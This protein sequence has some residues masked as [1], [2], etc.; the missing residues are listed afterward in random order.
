MPT[1]DLLSRLPGNLREYGFRDTAIRLATELVVDLFPAD[2]H[3]RSKPS[4]EELYR[5][6][7]SLHYSAAELVSKYVLGEKSCDELDQLLA[8]YGEA[9]VELRNRYAEGLSRYP[10]D[11][12]L[13]EG[14]SFLLY[15]LV[16]AA[17]PRTV[18]ETGVANGHSSFLV[19]QAMLANGCGRLHS[20]DIASDVGGL[21][22]PREKERWQL[23]LLDPS[24]LK[25]SFRA[26]LDVL[27]EMDLFLHD[28]DH[29][30]QW[31]S[32][33]LHAVS[34]RLAKKAII[35]ADDVD[36]SHAFLDFCVEH[37]TRPILL[38]DRRKVF[39]LVIPEG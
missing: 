39:G 26:L 19:L 16:R 27:P 32:Y 12:A 20:V 30:Y 3:R 13:E 1:R 18:L 34:G 10:E 25:K 28:S 36:L 14:S 9:E 8:E 23:H 33:E 2:F 15:A 7:L 22:R 5:A 6:A 24:R 11:Y 38:I 21:L 35:A 4:L 31:Q 37:R 17:R 29:T